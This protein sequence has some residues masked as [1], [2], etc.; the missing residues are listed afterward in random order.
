M[1]S[2]D[3]CGKDDMGH[4]SWNA[5]YG[6]FLRGYTENHLFSCFFPSINHPNYWVPPCMET[7]IFRRC[8]WDVLRSAAVLYLSGTDL[9][10]CDALRCPLQVGTGLPG[11]SSRVLSTQEWSKILVNWFED[12]KVTK[13]HQKWHY[14][15]LTWNTPVSDFILPGRL[16]FAAMNSQRPVVPNTVSSH[17]VG[18][19][20]AGSK[21]QFWQRWDPHLWVY[22]NTKPGFLELC[23]H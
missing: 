4:G 12:S 17:D 9:T 11:S 15:V 2:S 21:L 16:L 5:P 19:C 18:W 13:S 3:G 22:S 10:C 14:I 6:G 20:I 23:V 8:F 1:R 7:P